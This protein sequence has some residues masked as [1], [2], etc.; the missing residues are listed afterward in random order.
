MPTSPEKLREAIRHD[1]PVGTEGAA[2]LLG[3]SPG[4]L[5][6]WRSKRKPTP[7]IEL[8][9]GFLRYLPSDVLKWRES[10]RRIGK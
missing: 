1:L 9:R 2:L 10:K 5:R 8:R 4:T 6:N 7:C 3:V